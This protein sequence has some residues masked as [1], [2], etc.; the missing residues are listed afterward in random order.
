V[1]ITDPVPCAQD[2][3]YQPIAA[4]P[5]TQEERAL[6][7]QLK[8]AYERELNEFCDRQ[9][10]AAS[11]ILAHLSRLQRTHVAD[12]HSNP[13]KMWATIKAVHVQQVPGMRLS[14]YNNLFSIVMGPEETLPAVASRVKEAIAHVVELRPATAMESSAIHG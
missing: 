4:I 7:A 3:C 1:S 9:E 5:L 14:A 10:K 2:S 13:A 8:A 11:D 6:N 12:H